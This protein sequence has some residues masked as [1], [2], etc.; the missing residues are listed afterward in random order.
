MILQN[1]GR[2]YVRV[3]ENGR[4]YVRVGKKYRIVFAVMYRSQ[5]YG[6]HR[7]MDQCRAKLTLNSTSG[8][9]SNT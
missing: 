6:K 8:V 2:G 4:V 7:Q 9:V 5:V 3:G 1:Y